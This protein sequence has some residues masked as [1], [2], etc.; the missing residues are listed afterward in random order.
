MVCWYFFIPGMI[1]QFYERLYRLWSSTQFVVTRSV[2][3]VSDDVTKLEL[4][5]LNHYPKTPLGA[6]CFINIPAISPFQWHP[7]SMSNPLN[8]NTTDFLVKDMSDTQFAMSPFQPF[9]RRLKQLAALGEKQGSQ[10]FSQLT[11]NVDGPYGSDLDLLAYDRIVLVAGGI[12][13]TP[14]HNVFATVFNE[15]KAS[16]GQFPSMELVWIARN[17]DMFN[18]YIETFKQFKAEGVPNMKISLF[19]T[20]STIHKE[21]VQVREA[22]LEDVDIPVSNRK[23]DLS[24]EL[25]YLE[26]LGSRAL[27]YACGPE[28]LVDSCRTL[29]HRNGNHFKRETFIF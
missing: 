3:Q 20:R 18:M 14:L 19:A 11:V 5:M 24:V 1:L 7:F 4:Y 26:T 8:H 27:I 9:S 10:F 25:R 6:F 28:L 29:A 16:F 12:G 21:S 2:V 13:I 23:P 15:A 22:G 17:P